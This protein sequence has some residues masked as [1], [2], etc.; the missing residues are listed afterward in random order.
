MWTIVTTHSQNIPNEGNLTLGT[1]ND[2]ERPWKVLA[3]F[4]IGTARENKS[5]NSRW[6][7]QT[8]DGSR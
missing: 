3:T 2:D 6:K 8:D 1:S 4:D 5:V 7:L